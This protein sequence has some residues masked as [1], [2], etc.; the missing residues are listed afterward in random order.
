MALDVREQAAATA[1]RGAGIDPVTFEVLKNVFEY[2]TNRMATVLQRSS[3]SP[4][5]ADIVD[6]SNAVYDADMRCLAQAA[7]CP[8]HL[9]AMKYSALAAKERFGLGAI[10][11]GDVVALNDPYNGGSHLPD[12]TAIVPVFA[13]EQLAFWSLNRSHQSDI[14]GATHG[15]YNA[16]ATEIWHEG[17]RIPPLKLYDAGALREDLLEMLSANVRHPSDFKGDLF[18]MIGSVHIGE[19]RLQALIREYGVELALA[20]SQAVMD[21][22]ER[23]TR[24]RRRFA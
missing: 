19:R 14:G 17:L 16:A 24:A 9:A 15:A 6:F 4:I 21:A 10:E 23:Q 12:V 8:V 18:A 1:R 11:E 3:F 5:L 20:A 13:D 22:A 7:N 2:A